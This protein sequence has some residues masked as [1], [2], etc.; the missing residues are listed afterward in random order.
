MKNSRNISMDKLRS[1]SSAF[2]RSVFFDIVEF[3]DFAHINWMLTQEE[4]VDEFITYSD[5]FSYLYSWLK[6]EYQCE[7]FFK[8]EII[9]QYILKKLGT[10]NSIIF[11]EFRVGESIVDLAMFN[12]ES[13]AFEIKTNFDSPKRLLKQL[14]SYRRIFNKV[15]LIVSYDRLHQYLDIIP[16]C[17]G[18]LSLSVRRNR[19]IIDMIREAETSMNLDCEVLMRC[20]RTKEYRNIVQKFY[21]TLPKE[22]ENFYTIC[23]DALKAIPKQNLNQLFITEIKNRKS[24]TNLLYDIPLEFRQVCLSL[25]LSLRKTEILINNLSRTINLKPICISRI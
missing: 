4:N 1:Y 17:I 14:D 18:V 13:K 9:S 19:V 7:Y 15:Y 22:D 2:S 12:G 24:I 8:N 23:L 20:L 6:K 5:Y 10:E 3:G 25:N 21:Q 16:N 11:N